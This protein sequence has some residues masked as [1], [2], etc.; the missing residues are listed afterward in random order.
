MDLKDTYDRIAADWHRDHS[1]DDWWVGGLEKFS[2][3][4]PIGAT[5]LDA[6]CAGG[7]KSKVLAEKGFRVIGIDFAPK[8]IEIAKKEVPGVTFR[9]LDIKDVSSMEEMFDGIFLQAVLLHFPK[10]EVLGILCGLLERLKPG[11]VIHISVKES[12]EGQAEEEVQ[13]EDDYGYEYQR[14]FSFFSQQELEDILKELGSDMIFSDVI[15]SGKTRWVQ[16]IARK[17]QSF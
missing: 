16:I 8:F 14:F 12:R 7:V 3:A 1:T 10:K 17:R 9:V 2:E 6:G 11:G 13:T 15:Q 5:V 4:L